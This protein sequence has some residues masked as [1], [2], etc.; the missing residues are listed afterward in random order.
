MLNY[1]IVK[2]KLTNSQISKLKSGIKIC[3]EVRKY[4]SM[5]V[6]KPDNFES[7]NS[8]KS[9]FI[10]IGGLRPNF[11]LYKSFFESNSDKSDVSQV[12]GYH[13]KLK[14]TN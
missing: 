10:N 11:V 6:R 3:L 9:S 2:T 13:G 12:L 5:E 4:G 7:H 8:L 1:R 14:N